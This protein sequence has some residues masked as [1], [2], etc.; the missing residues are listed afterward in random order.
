[1]LG[2]EAQMYLTAIN[3]KEKTTVMGEEVVYHGISKHE[4]QQNWLFIG[5]TLVTIPEY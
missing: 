5:Q 3:F 4:C 2:I 1:M